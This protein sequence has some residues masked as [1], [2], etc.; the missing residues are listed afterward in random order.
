MNTSTKKLLLLVA[1]SLPSLLSTH[2]VCAQNE[3]AI[4]PSIYNNLPFDMPEVVQP[5]FP[6][7]EVSI[8]AFGAR[9]DGKT[10]NTKAINDAIKAVHAQGGG[11]VALQADRCEGGVLEFK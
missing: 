10:L 2:P 11:R 1:L 3:N 7:Y 5:T 8:L 4:D 9:E 6:D